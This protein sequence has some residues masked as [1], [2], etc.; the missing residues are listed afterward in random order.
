MLVKPTMSA[1]NTATVCRRTAPNG[2]SR[3]FSP[4]LVDMLAERDE[5]LGAVRRQ[6]VAVLFADIVGFTSKAERMAPES[7]VRM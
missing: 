4:N 3:Y 7:V 6:T 2:S 1:N 5:P